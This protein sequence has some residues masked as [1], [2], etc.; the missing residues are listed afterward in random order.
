M[1][2]PVLQAVG[3]YYNDFSD[4]MSTVSFIVV[5][6]MDDYLILTEKIQ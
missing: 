4:K 3:R 6:E 2:Q 1:P 5:K